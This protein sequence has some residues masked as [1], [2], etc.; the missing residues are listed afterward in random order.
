VHSAAVQNSASRPLQKMSSLYPQYRQHKENQ[1]SYNNISGSNRTPIKKK[2]T[3]LRQR[4]NIEMTPP[5]N[6]SRTN[7]QVGFA[8]AQL[9]LKETPSTP[10]STQTTPQRHAQS[11]LLSPSRRML[12]RAGRHNRQQQS[13]QE[14]QNEVNQRMD[15]TYR[16]NTLR[17]LR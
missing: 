9:M 5:Q 11:P 15:S 3:P 14:K 1:G 10:P 2:Y 16:I 7:E 4:P 6:R 13:K 17:S 8:F 12:D